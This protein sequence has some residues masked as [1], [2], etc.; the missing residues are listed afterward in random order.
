MAISKT[1]I[2]AF[3]SRWN[4][5]L[6]EGELI[7]GNVRRII[8][9][10]DRA[11]ALLR[12]LT[13]KLEAKQETPAPTPPPPPA[14][15]RESERSSDLPASLA[16]SPA[17]SELHRAAEGGIIWP[18]HPG[19]PLLSNIVA[20][21]QGIDCGDKVSFAGKLGTVIA[22]R[23]RLK[24]WPCRDGQPLEAHALFFNLKIWAALSTAA[25]QVRSEVSR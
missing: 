25:A 7:S 9:D 18:V 21:L 16:K 12:V 11:E 2:E 14:A 3:G 19:R 10:L 22:A 5:N 15:H 23:R 20:R 4:P 1:I 13:A 24:L 6:H 17:I 8:S